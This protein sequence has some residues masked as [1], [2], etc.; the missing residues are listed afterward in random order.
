MV[1][2]A[3]FRPNNGKFSKG[4]ARD[5]ITR[6]SK[7]KEKGK[8]II[9]SM[10]NR[11]SCFLTVAYNGDGMLKVNEVFVYQTKEFL[12]GTFVGVAKK[13]DENESEI[14]H[15]ILDRWGF[16]FGVSV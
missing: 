5:S 2:S 10:N 6:T 7:L 11:K 14:K 3:R 12:A 15:W 4:K 13:A 9:D 1:S 16:D 8:S